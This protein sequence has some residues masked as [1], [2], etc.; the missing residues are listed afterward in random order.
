MVIVYCFFRK[1]AALKIIETR[2]LENKHDEKPKMIVESTNMP[3]VPNPHFMLPSNSISQL[4]IDDH[5][6]YVAIISNFI[7]ADRSLRFEFNNIELDAM[8]AKLKPEREKF[9]NYVKEHFLEKGCYSAT[10][11]GA[12]AFVLVGA[13]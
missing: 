9:I 12:V 1:E 10:F 5:R 13:F 4:S 3:W 6:R 2:R 7:H 11:L 8:D